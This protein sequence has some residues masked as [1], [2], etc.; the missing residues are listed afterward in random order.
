M[1]EIALFHSTV[2]SSAPPL[3]WARLPRKFRPV[4]ACRTASFA[5]R[6][7]YLQQATKPT[8]RSTP[9][10]MSDRLA[11][12]SGNTEAPLAD[13]DAATKRL[14]AALDAL[15][16]SVE[17][18]RE[19]DRDENELASR[20]Q[21]LGADRSRLADELDG[22]LV[23]TRKLER[24]NREIAEKLDAAIGSIRAVLDGGDSR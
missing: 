24:A 10:V 4:N 6:E 23:K 14:M 16:S 3:R 21:A 19:A 11:N 20:I 1:P 5:V 22:S 18:R 15:E 9:R 17:R 12:G 2:H 7:A 13:I 8:E